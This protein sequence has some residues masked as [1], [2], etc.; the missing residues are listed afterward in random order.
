VADVE[1][2]DALGQFGQGEGLLQGFLN[3]AC[4]GLQDAEALV[5]GLLGVGAGEIDQFAFV[6]ALRNGDVNSCGSSALARE[7][8]AEGVFKFFAVFE[9]DGT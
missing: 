4:V 8:L 7:L 2:L 9:V 3:G 1:A 6:S 5:V